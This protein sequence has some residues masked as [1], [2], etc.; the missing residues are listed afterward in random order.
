MN[1]FMPLDQD[2]AIITDVPDFFLRRSNSRLHAGQDGSELFFSSLH[3]YSGP[4]ILKPQ[5]VVE[6]LTIEET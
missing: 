1:G 3:P 6:E 4:R 5:A 2:V